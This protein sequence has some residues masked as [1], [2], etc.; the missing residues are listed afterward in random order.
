[1]ICKYCKSKKDV[2]FELCA[3]C[4]STFCEALKGGLSD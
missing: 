3:D 4:F 2:L 1:M